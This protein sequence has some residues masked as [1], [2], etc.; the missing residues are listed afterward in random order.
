LPSRLL[1]TTSSLQYRADNRLA[2]LPA[3]IADHVGQLHVHLRERLL[4][5]LNAPRRIADMLFALPPVGP[6][7]Q[8]LFGRAK[9][10]LQQPID[11][12]FQQPLAFLNIRF[13]SRQVLRVGRIHQEH[14]YAPFRQNVVQGNPI[15]SRRLHGDG[16]H[17][18]LHQPIG[19]VLQ[20]L[21]ETSKATHRLAIQSR[22]DGDPMFV[23]AHIYTGG[24]GV[25][26]TQP[27][28]AILRLQLRSVLLLRLPSGS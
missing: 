5:T 11:V 22:R 25:N 3:D 23:I 2:S 4:H 6:H 27:Q 20:V 26:N 9:R 18:P 1:A 28:R 21:R 10:V 16:I 24:F 15:H 14:P 7:H 12:H 13:S 17:S 8:D 19:H